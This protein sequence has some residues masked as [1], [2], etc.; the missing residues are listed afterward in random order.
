MGSFLTL[1]GL[2]IGGTT[3][4]LVETRLVHNGAR[5]AQADIEECLAARSGQRALNA[6][7]LGNLVSQHTQDTAATSAGE[8]CQAVED[9]IA[10]IHVF[11]RFLERQAW[12]PAGPAAGTNIVGALAGSLLPFGHDSVLLVDLVKGRREWWARV[13]RAVVEMRFVCG[14]GWCQ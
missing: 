14:C 13:C 3:S 7:S 11:G 5:I 8:G 12:T 4:V 10:V 9:P 2:S 6:A 1:H